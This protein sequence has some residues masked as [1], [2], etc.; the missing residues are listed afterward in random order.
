MVY[1]AFFIWRKH[2]C[3]KNEFSYHRDSGTIALLSAFAFLI[4]I[5][6]AAVH[7]IV[8]RWSELTAWILTAMSLYSFIFLLAHIK[9]TIHR[10]HVMG[11]TEITLRNGLFGTA[12]IPY[13]RIAAIEITSRE[14]VAEGKHIRRFFPFGNK[15]NHNVMIQLDQSLDIEGF[16]GTTQ[17]CDVLLLQIDNKSLFEEEIKKRCL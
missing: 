8:A 1:Y 13:N 6:T 12:S 7:L 14:P 15:E 5:E 10:P 9:A 4:L 16:F 3:K 17:L 11:A 2:P